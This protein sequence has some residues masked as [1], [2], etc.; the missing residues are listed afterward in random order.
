MVLLSVTRYAVHVLHCIVN[1][2]VKIYSFNILIININMKCFKKDLLPKV[3]YQVVD[4]IRVF[5]DLFN[6]ILLLS[7]NTQ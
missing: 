2:N 6:F 5:L 7:F 3:I 4:G 1:L